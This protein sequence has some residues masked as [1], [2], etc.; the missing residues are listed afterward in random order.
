MSKKLICILSLF[1]L[2]LGCATLS[3]LV[4]QPTVKLNT[5]RL[6]NFSFQD[7][8]LNFELAV[9][10][11]NPFGV[12]LAGYDFQFAI[13]EKNF[14]NGDQPQD[15]QIIAN[16]T[17]LLT[18]PLTLKFKELYQMFQAIKDQD[19]VGYGFKGHVH[20][21]GPLDILKIP[22]STTGKLPAV[23]LPNISLAGV[24]VQSLSLTGVKLDLDLKIDNPNI[25]GLS[26]N[27]L[28]YNIALAGKSLI[29]GVSNQLTNITEKGSTSLHFPINLDFLA[30]GNLLT[31]ALQ[32]G[33]ID[34]V[35]TG[36]AGLKTQFGETQ[37]PID[38][39]GKT[40]LWR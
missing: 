15:V 8:T 13:N 33:E 2:V 20:V 12:K 37:L 19:E 29:N 31:T 36:G 1:A 40:K 16:Q 17:S 9:S 38:K 35:L 24:K 21:R 23:K 27:N 30:I 14:L 7:I 26:L 34:Y 18:V 22:F 25:F 4:Q 3:Q 6:S 10:N 28:N 11:P 5:V 39:T 32:K